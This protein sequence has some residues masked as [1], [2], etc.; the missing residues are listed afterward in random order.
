MKA[1]DPEGDRSLRYQLRKGPEGMTIN[2]VLGELRWLPRAEQAGVH[3][4]EIA[5]L[6]SR[7]ATAVQ[8][9]EL[10]VGAGAPPPPAAPGE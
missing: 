8:V 5:V 10:T 4:V 3:P 2:P 6:D 1:R 7:G 9:F